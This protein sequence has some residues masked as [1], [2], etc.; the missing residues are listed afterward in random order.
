MN[1]ILD[2]Y[3]AL[4]KTVNRIQ[5]GLSWATCLS[6]GNFVGTSKLLDLISTSHNASLETS[7]LL[8]ATPI[9]LKLQNSSFVSTIEIQLKL[10]LP[11]KL[12]VT[13]ETVSGEIK[14]LE[15]KISTDT[16]SATFVINNFIKSVSFSSPHGE[17]TI[18]DLKIYTF[19]DLNLSQKHK[20][21]LANQIKTLQVTSTRFQNLVTAISHS[22]SQLEEKTTDLNEERENWREKLAELEEEEEAYN[23]R[24]DILNK[25][26]KTVLANH[27]KAQAAAEEAE[28]DLRDVKAELLAARQETDTLSQSKVSYENQIKNLE[29]QY[30]EQS[31]KLRELEND[32]DVFSEDLRDYTK[33]TRLQTWFYGILGALMIGIIVCVTV[34][35]LNR[36]TALIELFDKQAIDSVIDIILSRIPYTL[37]VLGILTLCGEG[38]R[39]S[40]NRLVDIHDQRLPFYRISIAARD[41]TD[42]SFESINVD[43]DELVKTRLETKMKL[44]R[45]HMHKDLANNSSSEMNPS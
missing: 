40:V 28:E 6:K 39:R 21:K 36:S 12:I 18:K 14:S 22:L 24:I 45:L 5:Q 13:Y 1:E 17:S 42:A 2:E 8:K 32:I 43:R 34:S 20:F 33:E 9:T 35:V 26:Y 30:A 11:K 41:I 10:V 38:L 29:I 15:Q 19:K 3:E 31:A 16:E 4:S 37:A 7:Y 23:E 27:D 25:D 44:L